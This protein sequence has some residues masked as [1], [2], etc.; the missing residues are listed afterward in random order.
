MC[1]V[2]LSWRPKL[3]QLF[4]NQPFRTACASALGFS[5]LAAGV[6]PFLRAWL[7]SSLTSPFPQRPPHFDKLA[8]PILWI[9]DPVGLRVVILHGGIGS[10]AF[11]V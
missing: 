4:P 10:S 5:G 6:Q 9:R 7:T 11:A 2:F 3:P 1:I 8:I